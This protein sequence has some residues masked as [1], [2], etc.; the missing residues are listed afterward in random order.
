MVRHSSPTLF[1]IVLGL[2]STRAQ[3]GDSLSASD[4]SVPGVVVGLR[5]VTRY[6]SQALLL[7]PVLAGRL[8]QLTV[9]A[10]R[11]LA[12]HVAGGEVRSGAREV[13]RVRSKGV[14]VVLVLSMVGLLLLLRVGLILVVSLQILLRLLLLAELLGHVHV[15]L[16]ALVTVAV[17]DA[18]L[19]KHGI[20]SGRVGARRAIGRGSVLSVEGNALRSGDGRAVT[21]L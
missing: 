8:A 1:L 21:S 15:H 6:L 10:K 12:L 7:L 5:S 19:I 20:E 11:R 18:M 9:G 17:E 14:V 2:S 3:L 16:E 13:V 4:M